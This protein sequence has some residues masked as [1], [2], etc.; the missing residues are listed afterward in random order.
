MDLKLPTET[1]LLPSKGLLY[2]S[3]NILSSGSVEMC[4]M[5]AKHEDILTNRN[6][7]EQGVVIDKLLQALI[8]TK[9]NYDDLL[10]G[11]KNAILVA[12][13]ILGYGKDYEVPYKNST[14]VVD[15]S[16]LKEK[17]IDKSLFIQGQNEFSYTLPASGNQ[18]TFKFLTHGDEKKI[19]AELKGLKKIFPN[20][21][22]EMST[23]IKHIIT[24]VE[25]KRD[26]V[27]IRDFVDNYL[28]ARDAKALRDYY[29]LIQ[30]DVDMK[31]IPNDENYTGEGINVPIGI[32]FFWPDSGI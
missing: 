10:I 5:T 30:P 16:L 21:S 26:L 11:D 24:S 12:A 8:I 7:I 22:Y 20:N 19:D 23:R 32:N 1:V 28:I 3:D 31:Y 9:I 13:R 6:F 27:S 2:S 17:E 14:Q 25:G 29:N 15:L 4:Y 18:V